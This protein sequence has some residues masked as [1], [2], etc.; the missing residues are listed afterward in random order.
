MKNRINS[1]S[2]VSI[3]RRMSVVQI[4]EKVLNSSGINE[5]SSEQMLC[6]NNGI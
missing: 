2:F 6:L 3:Q 1:G 4:L 5:E